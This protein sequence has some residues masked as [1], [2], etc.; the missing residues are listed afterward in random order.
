MSAMPQS[1]NDGCQFLIFRWGSDRGAIV[2]QV[3][4]EMRFP[5]AVVEPILDRIFEFLATGEVEP[6]RR[7][8]Q[9]LFHAERERSRVGGVEMAVDGT[10]PFNLHLAITHA[11]RAGLETLPAPTAVDA[12]VVLG[13]ALHVYV[14]LYSETAKVA[15]QNTA[16]RRAA[17]L[18]RALASLSAAQETLLQQAR[19]KAMG[20]LADG[21]A[22][23]VNNALNAVLLRTMLLT[24]LADPKAKA[25]LESIETVVRSAAATVQRLQEFSRRREAR[26]RAACDAPTVVRESVALTRPQWTHRAQL[27]GDFIEVRVEGEGTPPIQADAGELRAILVDL[28]LNATEAIKG[29]GLIEIFIRPKGDMVE[30]EVADNGPGIPPEHIGRIFEPFFT[31]RGPRSSGLGLAM[32]WGVMDRLGGEIRAVNR[33]GGGASF[34]LAIP[35]AE[36]SIAQGKAKTGAGPRGIL[37]VDDDIES[38]ETLQQILV[39]RGHHVDIAGNGKE[40]LAIYRMDLHDV[41]LCDVSM[42]VMNGLQ[43][44]RAVRERN[45]KA[46]IALLTGWNADVATDERQ[47]VDDVFQ[48][49]VDVDVIAKFLSTVEL[50][51]AG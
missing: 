4:Q 41:V 48:K 12:L 39:L 7:A 6:I 11:L 40:A 9:K 33:P 1:T 37:L 19:L 30:I 36:R 2:A 50:P 24:R 17:E 28:V 29:N 23:D 42:P 15:V 14:E 44:A 13:Q 31:T 26:S 47:F 5:A 35:C 21:V 18:E 16:E 49:P 34:T 22:H 45:P 25:H 10:A 8:V 3:A 38:C 20:S 46:K 51:V 27:E 43:L 32:A